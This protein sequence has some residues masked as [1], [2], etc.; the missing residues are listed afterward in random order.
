MSEPT[1]G[2]KVCVVVGAGTKYFSNPNFSDED[3][4]EDFS[5]GVKMGLGGALPIVF[6]QSGY[7]VVIMS[8]SL[9]NLRPIEDYITKELGGECLSLAC[10]VSDGQSVEAAFSAAVEQ[11]GELDVVCFNAGYDQGAVGRNAIFSV[12]S[13]VETLDEERFED[14][15]RVHTLGLLRCAKQVLPAMRGRRSGAILVSGNSMCV[16]GSANFG[17]NSPSKFAQRSL[18][19]VMA[20]EYKPHGVHVSLVLIDGAIDAPGMRKL[21]TDA[22]RAEAVA[23]ENRDPGSTFLDPR[24]IARTFVYLAEQHRSVWTHEI[25]LTP[26]MDVLGQRL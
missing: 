16:R 11:C 7:R 26:Y 24:E 2:K 25:T 14:A 1:N 15:Y 4:S 5:P 22:G 13:L 9:E 20:Q 6:A 18:T 3:A 23:R 10:D 12:D 21:V 8:R 19:Q 17:Q